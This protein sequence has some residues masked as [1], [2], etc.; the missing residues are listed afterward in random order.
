MK[1]YEAIATREGR[2]WV[3]EVEG[4]GATQGRSVSEAREMARDLVST[5]LDVSVDGVD[6]NIEFLVPGVE[7]R[8]AREA[9]AEATKAQVRAARVSRQAAA[10]LREAGLTGR[11]AAEVLGVSPQRVSQ[12]LKA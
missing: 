3:I 7:V 11:D 2:W 9:V 1:V 12:L 4:V 8:A 5:M 6:V 10:K